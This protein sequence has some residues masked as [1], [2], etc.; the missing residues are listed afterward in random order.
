[1]NGKLQDQIQAENTANDV[2]T[3]T[4]IAGA[5][6]SFAGPLAPI[7]WVMAGGTVVAKIVVD[8]TLKKD[9]DQLR[10]SVNNLRA[11]VQ[12]AEGDLRQSERDYK[13]SCSEYENAQ[14][15]LALL[16]AKVDRFNIYVGNGAK[17]IKEIKELIEVFAKAIPLV[18]DLKVSAEVGYKDLLEW[19]GTVVIQLCK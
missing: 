14:L 17:R 9:V 4:G 11:D 15:K 16:N 7:G 1:M 2:M 19:C 6:L 3:G 8:E 5:V 13:S 10:S 12:K 18:G